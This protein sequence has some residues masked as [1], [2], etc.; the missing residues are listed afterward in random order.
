MK[1]LVTGSGSFVGREL[2][3][4]SQKLG[5]TIIG[6]D[7]IKIENANYEFHQVDIRSEKLPIEFFEDIDVLVHLAALSKDP[8]CKGRAY[9]CFDTNVMGTLNLIRTVQKTNLK[10]FVFASSEWVYDEFVGNEEKDEE[11]PINIENHSSEYAL[12]KLVSESNLRQ[13]HNQGFCDVTI[14]RFGIIYGPRKSNWSAVESIS[15]QV[16]H[17]NEVSVGSLKTGRRFIHVSD[18]VNGII[19]SIGLRG[20]N[21]I[22]LTGNKM[23]TLQEIIETSQ[24][25]LNK[26]IKVIET[27]PSQ[28]S[29]RNASNNKAKKILHW[30][31]TIDLETGLR[32]LLDFI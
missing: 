3:S 18:I 32:T 31:P 30:E 27:N 16:K 4:Q 19:K 13:Q 25:I 2:I 29:L 22:N 12:S 14:L 21:I 6:L 23:I 9:E 11:S 20:F 10:Q 5:H 15:S 7:S 26:S 28:M 24:R 1:I 8:D 17:K